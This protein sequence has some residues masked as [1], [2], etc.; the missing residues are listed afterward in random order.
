M[1]LISCV[2]WCACLAGC[3]S[4]PALDNDDLSSLLSI[5]NVVKTRIP[6]AANPDLVAGLTIDTTVINTGFSTVDVPFRMTWTLRR[7]GQTL[8]SQSRDFAAGFGPG[9]TQP[10]RLTLRFDPIPDLDG[11]TDAVTFDL[12]GVPST[13]L[14]GGS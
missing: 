9:D 5:S 7:S 11:T 4:K 1:V 14:L 10:V 6:D 3:S 12:L 2:V 13:S 8:A